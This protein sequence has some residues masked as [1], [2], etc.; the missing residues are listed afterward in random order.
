MSSRPEMRCEHMAR[1]PNQVSM[2]RSPSPK[3]E[4]V[5]YCLPCI[6]AIHG[7]THDPALAAGV[8]MEHYSSVKVLRRTA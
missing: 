4:L 1:D 7:L 2:Y 5:E 6:V 8:L 3:Q